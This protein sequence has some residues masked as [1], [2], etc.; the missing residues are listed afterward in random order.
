[1]INTSDFLQADDINKVILVPV[2]ISKGHYTDEAIE[3]YIGVNSE[4]RQG[5]YYRLAAEKLGLVEL[6]SPNHTVL[7]GKGDEFVK[8]SE[9]NRVAFMKSAILVLPVFIKAVEFM[10]NRPSRAELK[11]WF[12]A[13]YPGEEATAERRFSTFI[14]YFSYCG[15]SC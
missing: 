8:M 1:M 15:Y 11:A 12:I 5:R 3:D 4:G 10:S 6:K 9:A 2:A 14:K 7:T 13:F